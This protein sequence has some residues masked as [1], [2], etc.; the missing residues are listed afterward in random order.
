MGRLVGRG[1]LALTIVTT[2]VGWPS[3]VQL[4]AGRTGSTPNGKLG[5]QAGK[6]CLLRSRQRRDDLCVDNRVVTN[7]RKR[8]NPRPRDVIISQSQHTLISLPKGVFRV[9]LGRDAVCYAGL[10]A[11]GVPSKERTEFQTRTPS[12]ALLTMDEGV[13]ACAMK[14]G[15]KQ[16]IVICAN[17]TLK[18]SGKAYDDCPRNGVKVTGAKARQ[19]IAGF[20][21]SVRRHGHRSA[22]FATATAD[23]TL[24]GIG[25][26]VVLRSPSGEQLRLSEN[27]Q[28]TMTFATEVSPLVVPNHSAYNP[29]PYLIKVF[30]AQS[31]GISQRAPLPPAP[32]PLS[33]PAR[34]QIAF[35]S[36]RKG[37]SFQ[38][39]VMNPDGT[40]QRALT[41]SPRES[42]D[43]AWSPDGKQLVFESDR[44]TFGRSQLFVMNAD[45]TKQR[46][47][48]D[49]S[50]ANER[51]PKWSPDGSKIAFE[52]RLNGRSQ[53][54]LINPDGTG[55]RPLNVGS[56]E[57]SDP[58]WSPDGKRLVFTSNRS[59]KAH[60]YVVNLDGTGLKRLTSAAAP[61]RT[62]AWSPD[63]RLIV[64]E[65]DFSS[66]NAKL[67]VMNANG[68]AQRRLTDST[69]QEFH[70]AWSPD[71]T[72]I[73][74]AESRGGDSEIAIVNVDGG[75][76][77]LLTS[78]SGQ[79]LVP[80]W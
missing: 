34:T 23:I 33:K 3:F 40:G 61:D 4:Q 63:G 39:Y 11:S 17:D 45:G 73:V 68:S 51:F 37:K 55:L 8:V 28:V 66:T 14:T 77:K 58:A 75:G 41:A 1:I 26:T 76:E 44:A 65:R 71:G 59:G 35:E 10:D 21:A 31:T 69:E 70:P 48:G 16:E 64:F 20:Y 47:L 25:G 60:I 13:A 2:V 29:I 72:R 7:N 22:A 38:V 74:F 50:P 62:P 9:F 78:S 49:I 32:A 67:F 79:N 57:N 52:Y 43:P 5:T 15:R 53:I 18:T 80:E 19:K 30:N 36:N 24:E 56:G 54:D 46:M 6:I 27:R 42:F 12:H